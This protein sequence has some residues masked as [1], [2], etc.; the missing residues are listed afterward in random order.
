MFLNVLT[1]CLSVLPTE[2]GATALHASTTGSS[3]LDTVLITLLV[4]L[5]LGTGTSTITP[6]ITH[7]AVF[8]QTLAINAL[9]ALFLAISAAFPTTSSTLERVV[10]VAPFNAH[11]PFVAAHT[12]KKLSPTS[13][14]THRLPTNLCASG[15]RFEYISE[16]FSITGASVPPTDSF[17]LSG[18][19]DSIPCPKT[20]AIGDQALSKAHAAPLIPA[21]PT[22]YLPSASH[23]PASQIRLIPLIKDSFVLSA[24]PPIKLCSGSLLWNIDEYSGLS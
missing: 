6:P 14:A 13:Q 12:H 22:S 15:D 3:F 2:R 20:Q 7:F 19:N 17:T 16:P 9:S 11:A 4:I 24:R 18:T 23:T 10:L 1:I 21:S 5:F 8:C